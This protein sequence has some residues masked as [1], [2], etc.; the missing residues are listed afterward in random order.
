MSPSTK[1][2][3]LALL[4]FTALSTSSLEYLRQGYEQVPHKFGGL[5]FKKDTNEESTS[6]VFWPAGGLFSEE[7]HFTEMRNTWADS[8][9]NPESYKPSETCDPSDRPMFFKFLP[10][11][12]ATLNQANQ[13]ATF[14]TPC[15]KENNVQIVFVDEST[16]E[17][18]TDVHHRDGLCGEG[19]FYTTLS[20]FHTEAIYRTGKHTIRFENLT[21]ELMQEINDVGVLVFRLCDKIINEV[22]DFFKTLWL[23]LGG[24]GLNPKI[25]FFG[26]KPTEFQIHDNVRFIHDVTGYQWEPRN[27][28]D[29]V[30][31][32]DP[33][34]IHSGDFLAITRFDG[35]DQIIEYGAGSHAGHSTMLIWVEDE[36][37]VVESQAAWYWPRKGLQMNPFSDWVKW[38]H[39][40][41][42]NVVWLPLRPEIS[43]Q[44]NETAAY[45]WF[46]SVEGM[47]YGYHNFL[48]GWI[49]TVNASYPPLLDPEF[50][51]PLFEIVEKLQPFAAWEV[52]TLAMNMR[53][54]TDNLTVAEIAEAAYQRNLTYPDLFAMV[55]QDGW[56]YPDGYSYVCSAFVTAMYKAANLFEGLTINA[57]EFTPRDIYQLSWMD[58]NAN[59]PPNCYEV[60]PENPHCQIM[61]KWR[62][63]FPGFSTVV[64]Y[65]HMN[66]HCP[67]ISPLYE[68]TPGC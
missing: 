46:Q 58:T 55:E 47:P 54:G 11:L 15:F 37:Y 16:V 39:D 35:L 68:R 51:G 28:K 14:S 40:A 19:Y 31:D 48:W 8:H 64:P 25:P 34:L 6:V 13:A 49:D 65:D 56:W 4:C 24:L 57:V 18:I 17:V 26:S 52:F 21:P 3:I 43:A 53:L 10:N 44:F 12:V 30:V 22:P 61:G 42:F 32:I 5:H 50:I 63:Q 60:D 41:D 29:I 45:E 9:K 33:S 36:L 62:M 20:N 7:E 38:A 23:F 66:E 1:T 59:I 2:L 67:S 27:P